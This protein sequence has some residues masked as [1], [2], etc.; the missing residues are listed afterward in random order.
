MASA[1][2]VKLNYTY[3]K[4]IENFFLIQEIGKGAFGKVYLTINNDDQK[5]YATKVVDKKV[6]RD[7]KML[8]SFNKEIE[9]MS[10][11]DHKNIIKL[12][13]YKETDNNKYI[14]LEYCNGYSLSRV[15]SYY[16]NNKNI[17][18][19]EK[20]LQIQHIIGQLCSALKYIY[21]KSIL[22]RDIKLDNVL[23][24]FNKEKD[25]R[26]FI[27]LNSQ[28]KL[29]D[30]GFSRKLDVGEK[31]STVCGSP[32][33]M[34]PLI[35]DQLQNNT[36][37]I[38]Y[39]SKVDIWSLGSL[40]FELMFGRPPFNGTDLFELKENVKKRSYELPDKMKISK[41]FLGF[42]CGLLQFNPDDR[43]SWEEIINHDFLK[44]D[45]KSF[46]FC[47]LSTAKST[48]LNTNEKDYMKLLFNI[49]HENVIENEIKNQP[50]QINQKFDQNV[51][52]FNEK[53]ISNQI[54][55]NQIEEEKKEVFSNIV[56]P[57]HQ[58][59]LNELE[60]QPL[61]SEVN[62]N[63]MNELN[64]FGKPIS[65]KLRD[66][67]EDY[68]EKDYYIYK[69]HL[70]NDYKNNK[71][72]EIQNKKKVVNNLKFKEQDYLE[73]DD[74]INTKHLPN[75]LQNNKEIETHN[76]DKVET[77]LIEPQDDSQ[78]NKLLQIGNC[79]NNNNKME[80][81]DNIDNFCE[82]YAYIESSNE[83]NTEKGMF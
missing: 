32:Y 8:M 69:K 12:I 51:F 46:K 80:Q 52:K 54:K 74:E 25:K 76:N 66:K 5:K 15:L 36:K 16:K 37:Q 64:N 56:T 26:D 35:L 71:E 20:E 9:I 28:I 65:D 45:V 13:T 14:I 68:S 58:I 81:K 60:K 44:R 70:P 6:L 39:D 7:G 30:F 78:K 62:K 33:N 22:H 82:N 47:D 63:G 77:N 48:K 31:A 3:I 38:N 1:S 42:L 34:D 72:I 67:Q 50:T 17:S 53:Q 49:E 19:Q 29:I 41:E 59:K 27:I 55:N 23:L 18:P 61:Y 43:I 24:H 2:N 11:L 57:L 10:S 79:I 21:D 83:E 75:D 40:T 4:S 73:K